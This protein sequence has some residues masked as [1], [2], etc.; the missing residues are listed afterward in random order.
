[1]GRDVDGLAGDEESLQLPV[2]SHPVAVAPDVDD[3]TVMHQAVDQRTGHDVVA[4]DLA[5]FLEGLVG[6]EVR[7]GFPVLSAAAQAAGRVSD[8]VV[9]PTG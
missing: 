2:L 4:E 6:P 1:M 8:R 9:G 3:V 7:D 5:P